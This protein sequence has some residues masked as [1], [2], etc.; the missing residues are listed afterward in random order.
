MSWPPTE[1]KVQ[2]EVMKIL[3]S[4][5]KGDG[6]GKTMEPEVALS[7]YSAHL[8]V[9]AA[10]CDSTS[11]HVDKVTA[12]PFI[13]DEVRGALDYLIQMLKGKPDA[14]EK[15]KKRGMTTVLGFLKEQNAGDTVVL[16][17]CDELLRLAEG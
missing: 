9:R 10:G 12:E 4:K 17:G 7:M 6:K 16:Q 8:L 11:E 15:L 1:E 2:E 5:G 3:S 14:S 13:N